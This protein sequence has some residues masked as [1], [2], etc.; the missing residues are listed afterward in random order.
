MQEKLRFYA[1]LAAGIIFFL[2][3]LV[4]GTVAEQGFLLGVLTAGVAGVIGFALLY[5]VWG[6][7][8]S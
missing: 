1:S 8:T 5:I 2:I 6:R 7:L 4:S 3:A